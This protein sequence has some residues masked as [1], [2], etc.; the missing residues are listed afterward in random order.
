MGAANASRTPRVVSSNSARFDVFVV[1]VYRS[2]APLVAQRR[3]KGE[4]T[5]I[6]LRGKP[7]WVGVKFESKTRHT[8]DVEESQL[9]PGIG[10]M[11]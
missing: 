9:L 7:P 2:C 3:S 10:I 8:T 11:W 4:I 6:E 1:P 5:A